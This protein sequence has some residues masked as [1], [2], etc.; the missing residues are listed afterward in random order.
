MF[1]NLDKQVKG[2]NLSKQ[3]QE[4]SEFQIALNLF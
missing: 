3:Y 2:I 1:N 4:K